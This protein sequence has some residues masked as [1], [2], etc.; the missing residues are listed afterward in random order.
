[1]STL[2][3]D[4]NLERGSFELSVRQSIP[5]SGVTGIFGPSGSGKTTL[6]R[7]IAGLDKAEGTLRFAGR[8]WLDSARGIL[9]PTHQRHL[10]YVF[11]DARLF[12]CYTVKENLRYSE[13]RAVSAT[14]KISREQ[15]ID[16]L[17]IESL[18][19]AGVETLSGGERQRVALARALLLNPACLLLDEP[20][21][22]I[23]WQH[24]Q[25]LLPYL[26]FVIDEFGLPMLYVTHSL[27]EVA[28]LTDRLLL[29]RGGRVEQFGET[30]HVLSDVNA[31]LISGDIQ[32]GSSLQGRIVHCDEDVLLTTLDVE[33]QSLQVPGLIG[34]PGQVVRI[35]IHSRDVSLATNPPRGISIRNCLAGRIVA[36]QEASGSPYA[37]VVVKV[38]ETRVRARITRASLGELALTTNDS[39]FVLIKSVSVLQVS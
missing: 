9:V 33:G 26:R 21:A 2:D 38:G 34:G 22:A 35:L 19:N 25:E 39:I 20:L 11:Q 37:D 24:K 14:K 32:A 15:V 17:A 5:L 7:L 28:V 31:D 23:D 4:V 10:G 27:D 12:P 30:A 18:L 1:M 29:M 13:K 6:L 8:S 36:L 3:L 16:V